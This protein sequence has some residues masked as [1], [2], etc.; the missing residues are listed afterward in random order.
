MAQRWILGLIIAGI[1]SLAAM[2][3]ET[4]GLQPSPHAL[5]AESPPIRL[6]QDTCANA[7]QAQHD[8]CRVSTKGSPSCD[9]ARQRC[10]QACIATKKRER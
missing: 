3:A 9:L 1:F 5:P 8:Q 2:A 7:C 4:A 6:A 10:L